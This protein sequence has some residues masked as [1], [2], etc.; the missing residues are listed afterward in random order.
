METTTLKSHLVSSLTLLSVIKAE[1]NN[2]GAPFTV[3]SKSTGKDYTYRIGRKF[4]TKKQAWYT[5]VYV[6]QG[7]LN[8]VYLGQ[9]FNG[10]IWNRGIISTPSAKAIAH[11]LL[12][13]ETGHTDLLDQ[14]M[15]TMHSG[16]CMRCGRPLTDAISIERGLGPT[17]AGM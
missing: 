10:N 9:Y 6:E 2:N 17:C 11:V 15:E 4:G 12:N 5:N 8:F 13:V 16:Q 3:K 1:T 7:Y 14:Q